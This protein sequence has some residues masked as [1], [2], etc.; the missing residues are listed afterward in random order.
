MRAAVIALTLAWGVFAQNGPS[1]ILNTC[2]SANVN[3]AWTLTPNGTS[4]YLMNS[5]SQPMCMDIEMFNT[6]PG[7]TVWT[8]PCSD[9][10]K[11]NEWCA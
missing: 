7:A 2:S 5:G 8:W 4:L 10:S 1:L 9:G 6:A 3:Q 11:Q